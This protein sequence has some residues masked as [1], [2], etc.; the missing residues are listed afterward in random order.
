VW[1]GGDFLAPKIPFDLAQYD[2]FS[3]RTVSVRLLQGQP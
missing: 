1:A 3:I 2:P